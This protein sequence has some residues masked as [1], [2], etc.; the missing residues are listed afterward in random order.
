VNAVGRAG[1]P[2]SAGGKVAERNSLDAGGGGCGG[3]FSSA[4]AGAR[5]ERHR[6]VAGRQ[7][8]HKANASGVGFRRNAR[9]GLAGGARVVRAVGNK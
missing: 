4:K 6:P 9:G 3:D 8:P 5:I 1:R 2:A 7:G